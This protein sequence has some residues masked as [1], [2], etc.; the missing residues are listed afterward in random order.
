MANREVR[1]PEGDLG[2]NTGG[3]QAL[4]D[5]M[6]MRNM[7]GDKGRGGGGLFASF[8]GGRTKRQMQNDMKLYQFYRQVDD[9]AARAADARRVQVTQQNQANMLANNLGAVRAATGNSDEPFI[10]PGAEGAFGDREVAAG[11][12]M[13]NEFE[14]RDQNGNLIRVKNPVRGG[15]TPEGPVEDGPA[16]VKP[17]KKRTAADARLELGN[18]TSRYGSEQGDVSDEEWED[19]LGRASALANAHDIAARDE[20]RRA[21]SKAKK[22]AGGGAASPYSPEVIEGGRVKKKTSK[23]ERADVE[24]GLEATKNIAS[25]NEDASIDTGDIGSR[26]QPGGENGVVQGNQ[27]NK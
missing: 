26:P 2:I 10:L 18:L 16:Q 23:Q 15:Q 20:S 25:V 1:P 27:F 11:D 8:R 12:Y 19:Y 13:P 3:R 22:K 17:V 21:N 4:A 14:A 24:A 9:Q 6:A 7:L 5:F